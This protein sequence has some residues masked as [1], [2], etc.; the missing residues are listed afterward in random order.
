MWR[1]VAAGLNKAHHDEIYRR[2]AAHLFPQKTGT[3]KKGGRPRP[4]P[5]EMAEIWRCAASLERLAG[6][7]KESLG[8]A[9]VKELGRPQPAP[10]ALWCLGRIGAR[11][12]LYGPANTVVVKEKAERWTRTLL[13]ENFAQGRETTDAVFALGQLARVAGDRSLD[14]DEALRHGVIE[15]L[16]SL[17]ADEA[18]ILRVREFAELAP[19][20]QGQALGDSLPI[21]L[22]L[23]SKEPSV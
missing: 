2:L 1:R 13:D 20:Q 5:H 23:R 16:T 8:D 17:G 21:G 19:S 22:R 3:A 12:P 18:T 10:H 15:R 4:E 7:V 6:T 14:L 11:V 9:L